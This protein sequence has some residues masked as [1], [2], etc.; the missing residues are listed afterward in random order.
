MKIKRKKGQFEIG[1]Q[2][3]TVALLYLT[4]IFNRFSK[5]MENQG[6]GN[7]TMSFASILFALGKFSLQFAHFLRQF[8]F[9]DKHKR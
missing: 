9:S 3:F 8:L 7:F 2:V 6:F 1:K 5:Q 4:E